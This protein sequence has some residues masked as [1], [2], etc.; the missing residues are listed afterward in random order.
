[1]LKSSSGCGRKNILWI[2]TEE[3]D[4]EDLPASIVLGEL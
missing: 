1:M 2:N 4:R 3:A